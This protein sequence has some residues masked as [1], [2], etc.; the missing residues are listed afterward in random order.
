MCVRNAE[1]TSSILVP[2]TTKPHHFRANT[3]DRQFSRPGILH[4]P[5]P[6]QTRSNHATITLHHPSVRPLSADQTSGCSRG[7]RGRRVI[8]RRYA[9]LVAVLA[10]GC[11]STP[12][13]PT[14]AAVTPPVVVAS[15]SDLRWDIIAPG[16][17]VAKP[18]PMLNDRMA[19]SRTQQG[20]SIRGL[21]LMSSTR[22]GSR[23]TDVFTEGLF[24]RSGTVW[25]LCSWQML[26][27]D[28]IE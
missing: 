10:A 16:C 27:R 4:P 26:A 23:R 5:A 25:A 9:I 7:R 15:V 20:D 6:S 1:V 14:P 12:T 8:S 22:A 2:S 24:Q 17:V 18:V 11:S 19:D 3:R 13:S 21:W 28:T